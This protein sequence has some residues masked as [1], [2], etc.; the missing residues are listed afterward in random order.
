M[1]NLDIKIT[2]LLGEDGRMS[3]RE[4]AR[5][6]DISEPTARQRVRRLLEDGTIKVKAMM[7]IDEFPEMIIAYVGLKEMCSPHEGLDELAQIPEVIYAINTI[8]RYD[9]IAVI[10]VKSRE[11]L[12]NILTNEIFGVKNPK[13]SSS[14]THVVLYNRNLLL[15][16][17][18]IISALQSK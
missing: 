13:F 2:K 11:Q 8:G 10:A 14:E 12:A 3:Y 6:L 1:D 16:A 17:D 15:P 5:R 7:S 18:N 9:L 4:I